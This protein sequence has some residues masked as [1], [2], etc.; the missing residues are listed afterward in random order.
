MDGSG[1]TV[2][3]VVSELDDILLVLELGDGADGTENLLLHDLHVGADVAEDGGLDEVTLVAK[4]LA[5]GLDSGTL[6]LTGLDVAHDTVVLKLA[7]LGAL[8]SLL[9]E[10]VTDLVLSSALL[11]GGQELVVDAL[12]DEDT[13]TGAAALAVV[14]VN[15]EVDPVDGV[16]D[17]GVVENDV[18]GL[19][20]K[21]EGNLLEVGGGSGLH[22]G[23]ANDGGASEGDLVNVHVRGEGGTGS[24]AKSGNKVENTRRE[25]S[26]LNKLSED[27][28][29]QRSLLSS[30]HDNTVTSSQSRSDL[31]RQHE[32]REVPGDDLTADTKLEKMG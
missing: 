16:L 21:F 28:S 31:P 32:K 2:V 18:G 15:T 4:T 23:S 7:D 11:E 24:L 3:G 19:A 12:L 14:V 25:A 9:V 29:R 13:G 27:K 17:V 20:T 26:L 10:R 6:F 8:E 5:T 1:E 30:L 22:D